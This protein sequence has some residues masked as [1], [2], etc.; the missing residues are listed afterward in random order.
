MG[1]KICLL[2]FKSWFFEINYK[3]TYILW[4]IKVKK[5]LSKRKKLKLKGIKLSKT[6]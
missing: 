1:C 3:I 6:I 2:P 4:L 5:L